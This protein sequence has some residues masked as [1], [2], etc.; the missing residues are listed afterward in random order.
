[1]HLNQPTI[2]AWDIGYER[3]YFPLVLEKEAVLGMDRLKAS[4]SSKE[5]KMRLRGFRKDRKR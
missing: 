5:V 4:G 1:V 3:E 2:W